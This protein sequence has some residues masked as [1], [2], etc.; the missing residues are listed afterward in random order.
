MCRIAA[1][2]SWGTVEWAVDSRGDVPAR[3]FFE[4]LPTED[5]AK[6][7]ALFRRLAEDGTIWNREKFR[8]LGEK[9]GSKGRGLWEFKSFQIRLIGA[10]RTGKRF[11]IAHGLQKKKDNLPEQEIKKAIRI[12]EEHDSRE[13]GVK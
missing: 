1:K 7:N 5:Q 6:V 3:E 13:R 12:L 2:G 9:A 11:I 10:F 4:L 8:Q